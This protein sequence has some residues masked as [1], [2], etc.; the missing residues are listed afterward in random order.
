MANASELLH[1][2]S[3]DID[4]RLCS[5]DAPNVLADCVQMAFFSL[6]DCLQARLHNVMYIFFAP[7]NNAKTLQGNCPTMTS[8]MN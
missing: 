7:S 8:Y 5:T 1:F 4:I 2:V 3:R 6:V